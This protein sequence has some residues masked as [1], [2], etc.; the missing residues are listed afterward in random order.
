MQL[1][2][3][4][5]QIEKSRQRDATAGLPSTADI[6]MGVATAVEYQTEFAAG[7]APS[8]SPSLFRRDVF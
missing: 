3:Q 1:M 8:G 5:G 6:L 2:S 4:M 7:A